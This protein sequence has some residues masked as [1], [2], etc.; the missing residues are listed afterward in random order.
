M[1]KNPISVSIIMMNRNVLQ[2]FCSTEHNLQVNNQ[3]L[4][5]LRSYNPNLVNFY[6]CL[7]PYFLVQFL[8]KLGPY[9]LG[10]FTN[11]V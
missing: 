11:E 6:L 4:V 3:S 9:Y 2:F 8:E 1:L 5:S 10:N 7:S